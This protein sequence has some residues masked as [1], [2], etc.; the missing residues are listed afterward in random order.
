MQNIEIFLYR[1]KKENK[2][3]KEGLYNFHNINP[4]HICISKFNP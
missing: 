1:E 4:D 3:K 2:E